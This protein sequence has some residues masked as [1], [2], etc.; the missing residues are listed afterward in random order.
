M[1]EQET[2]RIAERA[3]SEILA[4]CDDECFGEFCGRLMIKRL[5]RHAEMAALIY[6]V[7]REEKEL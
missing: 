6:R 5:P 3:A 1:T 7:M 2:A 4:L